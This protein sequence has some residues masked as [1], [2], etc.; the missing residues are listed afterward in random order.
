MAH[1][2]RETIEHRRTQE[3]ATG[4]PFKIFD[5]LSILMEAGAN[6]DVSVSIRFESNE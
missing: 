4:T 3:K 1:V 2:R 6:R 5:L